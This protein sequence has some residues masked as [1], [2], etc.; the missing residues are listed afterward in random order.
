MLGTT[1]KKCAVI[2]THSCSLGFLVPLFSFFTDKTE[3]AD[4]V[5]YVWRRRW[6][7]GGGGTLFVCL[8]KLYLTVPDKFKYFLRYMFNIDE[9]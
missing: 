2:F 4:F 6:V 1:A 8:Q 9:I 3:L 7:G 5:R